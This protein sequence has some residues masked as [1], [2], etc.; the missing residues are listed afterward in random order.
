MIYESTVYPGATEEVY[1]PILERESGLRFNA[2][3]HGEGSMC[4][5]SPVRIN[6]GD[7][8]H[9]LT[10]ITKVTSSGTPEAAIWVD[11]FY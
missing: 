1:V 5:Y 4:Y 9:K 3:E 7:N 2:A 11:D 8:E 6:S 10:T